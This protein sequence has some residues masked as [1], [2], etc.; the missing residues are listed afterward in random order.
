[1]SKHPA[2]PRGA[3]SD[4]RRIGLSVKILAGFFA[5]K[6]LAKAL[7]KWPFKAAMAG[8]KAARVF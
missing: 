4:E 1:M 3:Q 6:S 8:F 5:R 2:V 7:T